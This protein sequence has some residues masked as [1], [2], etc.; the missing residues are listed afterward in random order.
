MEVGDYTLDKENTIATNAAT[1]PSINLQFQNPIAPF[2]I[3]LW[4][5]TQTSTCRDLYYTAAEVAVGIPREEDD[6]SAVT[7]DSEDDFCL[8]E[9]SRDDFN[10]ESSEEDMHNM[11][12][13][14]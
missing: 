5:Q 7:T 12:M 2:T 1:A 4:S 10:P 6:D 13:R 9:N 3:E 14:D 8:D 11:N